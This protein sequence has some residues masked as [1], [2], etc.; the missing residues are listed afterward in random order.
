MFLRIASALMLLIASAGGAQQSVASV[1]DTHLVEA[2]TTREIVQSATV[3]NAFVDVLQ[4]TGFSGG[5]ISVNDGCG[6]IPREFHIPKGLR[7]PL[8]LTQLAEKDGKHTWSSEKGLVLLVPSGALPILLQT[9]IGEVQLNDK[10]NL[11]LSLTQLLQTPEVKTK[12][13]QLRLKLLTPEVGFQKLNRSESISVPQ[14]FLL[15]NVSLLT[16]LNVLAVGRPGSVWSYVENDC[17]GQ[18]S[19][20]IDFINKS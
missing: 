12:T 19:V 16:A 3:D 8:A 7:L 11:T 20:R 18:K 9:K 4:G 6:S 1:A 2:Q 15:Q 14:P 10:S 13:A 5:A 17:G